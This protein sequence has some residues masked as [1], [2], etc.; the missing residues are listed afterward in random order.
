MI[1][2][3]FDV[4]REVKRFVF[5]IS[6]SLVVKG[7]VQRKTRGSERWKLLVLSMGILAIEVCLDFNFVVVFLSTYFLF[8]QVQTNY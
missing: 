8:R 6:R 4:T 3:V 2:A 7:S 5:Q 1:I